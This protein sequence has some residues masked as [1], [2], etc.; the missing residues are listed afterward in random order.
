MRA[1]ATR[2]R[3]AWLAIALCSGALALPQAPAHAGELEG[4]FKR[5]AKRIA[6]QATR[7]V[8]DRV[9]DSVR[10]PLQAT[11]QQAAPSGASRNPAIAAGLRYDAPRADTR[12]GGAP[13]S[14][15]LAPRVGGKFEPM[16]QAPAQVVAANP[17][18]DP[19]R[20]FFGVLNHMQCASDGSLVVAADAGLD[21]EG[22]IAG[23]GFWTIAADGAVSPLVSHAYRAQSDI[24]AGPAF[25]LLPGGG[26]VV[27]GDDA[28]LRVD[29]GGGVR[30]LASGLKDPGQPVVD[31]AG[32]VWF[33]HDNAC[34]LRR[35]APDGSLAT[36]VPR[37]RGECGA[38]PVAERINVRHIAWDP[39]H[40]ELVAGGGKI[41]ASPHDMHV[42]LWRIRPDGQ[43]RR[44][45]YT[46]KAGRSPVGQNTDAIWSVA[47]DAR[48]RIVVATRLLD[49]RARRQAMRLDEARGRLVPLT[50]QSFA[51][52]FGG[53]DYRPGHEEAPYDGPAAHASFREANDICHGPDGTLFVLDEHLVRRLDTDGRVRTWAY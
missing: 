22:G 32:N 44:V 21:A 19:Q 23:R 48:G 45:Y 6:D 4:L 50:G 42:T 5:A 36:V 7:Q 40:G 43:A 31:P 16:A 27:A 38:L 2:P 51:K 29:A 15:W 11:G 25:A 52:A 18:L 24:P 47:V 34:E 30:T 17:Y 14:L 39:V 37:E 12:I 49:D 26:L 53:N 10:Q 35:L 41:V 9:V 3:M 13:Q 28:L 46:V 8:E 1:V 33:A 20:P